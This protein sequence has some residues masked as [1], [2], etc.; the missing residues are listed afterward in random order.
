[1]RETRPSL[2][3]P[4]S[5]GGFIQPAAGE[6]AEVT[7]RTALLTK[8]E[9]DH[10]RGIKETIRKDVHFRNIDARNFWALFGTIIFGNIIV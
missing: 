7:E 1:M 3:T 9:Y 5:V 4:A 6:V 10:A 8:K 2:D